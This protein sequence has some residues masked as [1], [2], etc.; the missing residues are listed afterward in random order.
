[1]RYYVF[2]IIFAYNAASFWVSKRG[3]PALQIGFSKMT[4][5]WLLPFN[6]LG[7]F[8]PLH[9]RSYHRYNNII[10]YLWSEHDVLRTID[11]KK[12]LTPRIKNL[13]NAF[14]MEKNKKC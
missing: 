3:C 10:I 12:T 13:K 9:N 4:S 2:S 14:F 1:M 7:S 11:V 6:L 5:C 8:S